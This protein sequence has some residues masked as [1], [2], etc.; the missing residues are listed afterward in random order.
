QQYELCILAFATHITDWRD[1]EL[2][3]DFVEKMD[4]PT[5]AFSLGIQDHVQNAG[6]VRRVHPSMQR[7]LRHVSRT[8]G[9]IGVR[10]F[11]TASLLY[12]EGFSNVVPVGC[13]T[14]FGPLSSGFRV[15]PT[16]TFKRPL[17]VF[18]RTLADVS[19][20]LTSDVPLLGQDFLDEAIFTAGLSEDVK[21][22]E[23][24]TR[25]YMHHKYGKAVLDSIKL[26]GE[27]VHDF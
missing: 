15:S 12:K 8:T 6:N 24:E 17:N 26:N 16:E 11:Y 20:K 7:I 10:G 13:P 4:I 5:A 25:R 18:H 27:F 22:V 2:Y 19:V 1:V 3:A 21:L 23:A 14:L 9:W